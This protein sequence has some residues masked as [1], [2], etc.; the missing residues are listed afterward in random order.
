MMNVSSIV[1]HT[2]LSLG[3]GYPTKYRVMMDQ[4]LG[5]VP[6]QE[7]KVFNPKKNASPL[8]ENLFSHT[9]CTVQ[10]LIYC[11]RNLKKFQFLFGQCHIISTY[12]IVWSSSQSLN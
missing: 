5:F 2:A 3:E 10:F 12:Y 1:R 11:L 9:Y 8:L 6:G 4:Y 7:T